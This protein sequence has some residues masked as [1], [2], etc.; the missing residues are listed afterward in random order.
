MRKL[1]AGLLV[2]MAVGT[3]AAHTVMPAIMDRRKKKC[4][5]RRGRKLY[6]RIVDIMD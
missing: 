1:T 3:V 2:G 4:F 5:F 6:H